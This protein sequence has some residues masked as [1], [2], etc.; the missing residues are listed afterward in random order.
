MKK[1]SARELYIEYLDLLD[2]G[3]FVGEPFLTFEEFCI[4]E[5]ITP[6]DE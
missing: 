4:K 5:K 3:Y 2:R 1:K 6:K